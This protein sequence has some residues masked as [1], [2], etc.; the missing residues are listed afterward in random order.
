M[1][2]TKKPNLVTHPELM[3]NIYKLCEKIEKGFFNIVLV[4]G[5]TRAGKSTLTMQMAQEMAHKLKV[6][7]DV[8]NIHFDAELLMKDMQKGVRRGVF[9]LDEAAFNAKGIDWQNEVQKNLIKYVDTAA[10]YNQ[11][12]FILIPYIEELKYRFIRDEHTRLCEVSFNRNTLERGMAK[13]YTYFDGLMLYDLLK[14]K[15]FYKAHKISYKQVKFTSETGS[16]DMIEYERKKDEAIQNIG[17]ESENH[18]KGKRNEKKWQKRTITLA[19]YL[20][21]EHNMTQAQVAELLDIARPTL[22]LLFD[23]KKETMV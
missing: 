11:T 3:K 10:K 14:K 8:D 9:Q 2:E 18:V 17:K 16:I 23:N 19:K 13:L 4:F 15:Q 21:D 20:I 22:S 6:P 7:F 12:L 1:I 5:P